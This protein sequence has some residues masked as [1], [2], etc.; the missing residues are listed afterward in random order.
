MHAAMNA[1][2]QDPVAPGDAGPGIPPRMLTAYQNAAAHVTTIVPACKG[3]KWPILAGIAEVES[4]HA[5]GHTIADISGD[6]SPPIL[7][8]RLDGSGAGGN[9]TPVVDTDSGK[10]DNDREF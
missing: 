3:M 6:I 4:H 2:A 9:T 8:P 5:A 7:G 1:A 10:W